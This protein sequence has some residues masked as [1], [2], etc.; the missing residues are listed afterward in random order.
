MDESLTERLDDLEW[1]LRVLGRPVVDLLVPGLPPDA[2]SRHG[3]VPAR[4][5]EWFGWHDGVIRVAGQDHQD[6]EIIP[7]Y[8]PLAL[9]E[10]VGLRPEY[11]DDPALGDAWLPLLASEAGDLFAASWSGSDEPRVV[12]IRAGEPTRVEFPDLGA[13]VALFVD[14]FRRAAFAVGADGRLTTDPALYDQLYD[15]LTSPRG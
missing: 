12:A 14:C 1:W 11:D 7:G 2:T 4:V 8:A 13:M 3:P 9:A 15:E 5:A 6:I 10:A